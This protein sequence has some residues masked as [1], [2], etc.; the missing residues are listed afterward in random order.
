MAG[1]VQVGGQAMAD[2]Y[3]YLP[4]IGIF[5]AAIWTAA[6]FLK[7]RPSAWWPGV[8]A[9]AV[10]IATL[11]IAAWFQTRLWRDDVL[12]FR[13]SAAVAPGN[14]VA[15]NSL[16][17]RLAEQGKPAEAEE[18]FRLALRA[19]PDYFGTRAGYAVFLYGQGRLVEARE[20]AELGLQG[21]PPSG[22]AFGLPALLATIASRLGTA[23][24][25]LERAGARTTP[26]SAGSP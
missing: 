8:G 13:H 11:A 4:L 1:F 15:H 23:R 14:W 22:A 19:N 26:G 12:L 17:V 24:E 7:R 10:L 16:A 18:Q 6:A 20:Q 21:D 25:S 3:T 5:L 9:T 2:R